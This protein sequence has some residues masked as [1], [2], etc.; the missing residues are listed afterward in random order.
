MI[1]VAVSRYLAGRETVQSAVPRLARNQMGNGLVK[2]KCWITDL[3][4]H[5]TGTTATAVHEMEGRT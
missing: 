3:E 5:T 1:L 4:V 2:G